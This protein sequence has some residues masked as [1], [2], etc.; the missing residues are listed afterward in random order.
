MLK[1]INWIRCK[2]CQSY[3]IDSFTAVWHCNHC[4][5]SWGV[6]VKETDTLDSSAKGK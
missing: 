4:H 3:D 1:I 5:K 6:G 2:F